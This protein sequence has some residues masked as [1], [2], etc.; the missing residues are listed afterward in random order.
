MHYS[1]HCPG[2]NLAHYFPYYFLL[3]QIPFA[4]QH[5]PAL[6]SS[7]SLESFLERERKN[8]LQS[9]VSFFRMA[10]ESSLR[11]LFLSYHYRFLLLE[12]VLFLQSCF[13]LHSSQRNIVL[14]H[15]ENASPSLPG[16]HW[17]QNNA[18]PSK[19]LKL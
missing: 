15:F 1:R 9:P 5:L 13:G 10:L 17:H 8:A 2:Q 4:L 16:E 18:G 12:S 7:Q 3:K 19:S 11:F 14:P 6:F